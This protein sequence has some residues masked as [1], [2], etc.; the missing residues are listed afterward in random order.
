MH[1]KETEGLIQQREI[2]YKPELGWS[3]AR[4]HMSVSATYHHK[5]G[6]IIMGKMYCVTPA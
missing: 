1:C 5:R 4:S 3:C 6:E 2:S